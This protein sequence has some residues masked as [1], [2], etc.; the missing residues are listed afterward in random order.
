MTSSLILD[1]LFFEL[2]FL[3]EEYNSK[4]QFPTWSQFQTSATLNLTLNAD[5]NGQLQVINKMAHISLIFTW[6][7]AFLVYI[8]EFIKHPSRGQELLK[9]M[10]VIRTAA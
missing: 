2:V 10:Q 9:Y 4:T 1:L 8:L 7:E 5:N 3:E 6:T